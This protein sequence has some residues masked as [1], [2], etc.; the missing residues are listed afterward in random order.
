MYVLSSMGEALPFLIS[1]E[2]L[3]LK[4][5]ELSMPGFLVSWHSCISV[6]HILYMSYV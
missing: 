6:H 5:Q 4:T 3:L 1:A 2:A